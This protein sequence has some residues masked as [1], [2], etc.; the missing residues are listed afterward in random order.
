MRLQ[1]LILLVVLL[2]LSPGLLGQS[3][4]DMEP[5]DKI[6]LFLQQIGRVAPVEPE[7]YQSF[8][9]EYELALSLTELGTPHPEPLLGNFVLRSLRKLFPGLEKAITALE[10]GDLEGAAAAFTKLA[11]KGN[12][13]LSA[14]CRLELA[15][16][17]LAA[18][19]HAEA[20]RT[21]ERIVRQ[22]RQFL[23]TDHRAGAIIA[24]C[25]R[26][27]K[28]P[29]LEFLQWGILLVDYRALPPAVQTRAKERLAKLEKITGRPVQAVAGW[30]DTVQRLIRD[31]H[32]A[33]DPTQTKQ[34]EILVSL[35]KMIELQEARERHTCE[36][37]GKLG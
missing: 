17:D 34:G 24:E 8:L 27:Q 33:A 28:R 25:F 29:V 3:A 2:N 12:P 26:A 32:T 5:A 22:D 6:E 13:F 15:E 30:M 11:A 7:V 14:H 16:I 4:S 23:I 20:I 9:L 18:G 31:L 36:N 19:R 21:A 1:A 37:C 35:D 10:S